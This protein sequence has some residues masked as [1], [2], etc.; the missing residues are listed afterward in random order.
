MDENQIRLTS[1]DVLALLEAF[2]ASSWQEMAVEVNGDRLFVSREADGSSRRPPPTPAPAPAPAVTPAGGAAS[3]TG[4][5][6]T[7]SKG[8]AA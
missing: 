1:D 6:S 5:V 4:Q 8:F 7:S 2:E 3:E